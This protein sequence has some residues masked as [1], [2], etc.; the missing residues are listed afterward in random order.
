MSRRIQKKLMGH[1][2]AALRR[3]NSLVISYKSTKN[4]F[5]DFSLM[6]S[7]VL[8][9]MAITR[10]SLSQCGSVWVCE[11]QQELGTAACGNR[12]GQA[13]KHRSTHR[14]KFMTTQR[15][16]RPITAACSDPGG[17]SDS[18]KSF[19]RNEQG[20]PRDIHSTHIGLHILQIHLPAVSLK[21][22]PNDP[23]PAASFRV[24]DQPTPLS[25]PPARSAS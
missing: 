5:S 15:K 25:A 9:M 14:S 16:M 1:G 17:D 12:A 21:E 3:E 6:A 11:R 22:C 20:E 7:Y 4:T 13:T 2:A 18:R 23:P 8:D 19:V 10:L 24:R